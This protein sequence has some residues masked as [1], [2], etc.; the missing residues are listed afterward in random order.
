MKARMSARA[1]CEVVG[2]RGE[3]LAQRVDDPVELGVDRIRVG[4]S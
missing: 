2:H 1:L 3:L 4:W